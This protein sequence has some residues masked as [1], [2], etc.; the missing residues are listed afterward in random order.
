MSFFCQ[1]QNLVCNDVSRVGLSEFLDISAECGEFLSVG[2]SL[3]SQLKQSCW[4]VG[5]LDVQCRALVDES[6]GVLCL[7]VFGHVG[8]GRTR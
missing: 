4:S 5:V 1:F 8:R 2:H 6:H 7:V 3:D